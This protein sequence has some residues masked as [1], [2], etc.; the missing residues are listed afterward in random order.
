M[1]TGGYTGSKMTASTEALI[2]GKN[3]WSYVGELPTAYRGMKSVQY[4]NT[5]MITGRQSS[6]CCVN[7][8]LS[9]G[10][11]NNASVKS[12]GSILVYNTYSSKWEEV[13]EMKESRNFHAISTIPV[14]DILDYC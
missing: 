4:K 1:V 3:A 2:S 13:G 6:Y 8:K 5:V 14:K 7:H 11:D 10:Y 9:G 12:I